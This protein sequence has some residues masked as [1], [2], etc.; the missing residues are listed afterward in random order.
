MRFGRTGDSKVYKQVF[1][2]ALLVIKQV[3]I[4][5]IIDPEMY[6]AYQA[7]HG[8]VGA[9]PNTILDMGFG[10]YNPFDR[11]ENDYVVKGYWEPVYQPE[12]DLDKY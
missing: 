5:I 6:D 9:E 8:V 10:N 3:T 4:M 2:G 12:E 1:D 11:S 7:S